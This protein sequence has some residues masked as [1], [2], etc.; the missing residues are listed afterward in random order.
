LSHRGAVQLSPPRH[1]IACS[2][3]IY[4]MSVAGA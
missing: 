2:V 1:D 4:L 3:A